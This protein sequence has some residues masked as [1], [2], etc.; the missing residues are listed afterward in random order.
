LETIKRQISKSLILTS[1]DG[2]DIYVAPRGN[3]AIQDYIEKIRLNYTVDQPRLYAQFFHTDD[4]WEM[5]VYRHEYRIRR[6]SVM[7]RTGPDAMPSS[8][9]EAEKLSGVVSGYDRSWVNIIAKDAKISIDSPEGHSILLNI[10]E[11]L[12]RELFNRRGNLH[13]TL[14]TPALERLSDPGR[15]VAAALEF[16]SRTPDLASKVESITTHARSI[17]DDHRRLDKLTEAYIP[18]LAYEFLSFGSRAHILKPEKPKWILGQ[19]VVPARMLEP[20][21][22]RGLRRR[23]RHWLLQKRVNKIVHKVKKTLSEDRT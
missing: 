18:A 4:A 10:T 22:K 9:S 13:F 19:L 23:V 11:T 7:L 16:I 3:L 1:E 14:I 8:I 5:D 21:E 20:G 6:E 15:A 17:R 12:V 2:N